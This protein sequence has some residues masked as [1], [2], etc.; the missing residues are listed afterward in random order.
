[1]NTYAEL[2]VQFTAELHGWKDKSNLVIKW[3]GQVYCQES[4]A[5]ADAD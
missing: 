4:T 3:L 2:L 5:L 1:M